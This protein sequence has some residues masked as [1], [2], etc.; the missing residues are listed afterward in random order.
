MTG[1]RESTSGKP[2]TPAQ[3]NARK[4]RNARR[5]DKHKAKAGKLVVSPEAVAAA[6]QLAEVY[7][8]DATAPANL[9]PHPSGKRWRSRH[10]STA[11]MRAAGWGFEK[12]AG[13]LG[14]NKNTV[15]AYVRT[16]GWDLLYSY[17]RAAYIA[18]LEDELLEPALKVLRRLLSD[19]PKNKVSDFAALQ[20]AQTVLNLRNAREKTLDAYLT[21]TTATK[22]GGSSGNGADE[23]GAPGA[24]ANAAVQVV[25]NNVIPEPSERRAATETVHS[26]PDAA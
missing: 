13:V 14:Y 6:T 26:A 7:S 25:I 17:F 22:N 15:A 19:D 18:H 11:R 4:R 24:T 20:A 21:A 10:V 16:P 8:D 9:P 2:R 1:S 5:D 23:T 12:I 3:E